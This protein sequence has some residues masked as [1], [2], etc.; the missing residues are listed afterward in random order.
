[1]PN[2]IIT[3][4]SAGAS[5]ACINLIKSSLKID[6]FSDGSQDIDLVS[7]EILVTDSRFANNPSSAAPTNYFSNIL[8]PINFKPG[9]DSVQAE[10]HSR[11]RKDASKYTILLNNMRLMAI[12]DW[13]ESVRDFLSQAP[14]T[15]KD[16][17]PQRRGMDVSV[18][19]PTATEEEPMELVLN[20]TD[21]ELVF[22]ER[23]DQWDTNAVILKST[24]IV[25]Y[26]PAEITKV[27]SINL[28][29]LE[30]FSCVLGNEE[31]TALSIIDPVTVN[32][33]LR[34]NTL[35]IQLQK[36]L[37]IRLS[38]HDLKMFIQMLESLPKQTR[39]AKTKNEIGTILAEVVA[40]DSNADKGKHFFL[41]RIFYLYFPLKQQLITKKTDS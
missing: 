29:H 8:Q 14:D 37:C 22:V 24:T 1:M 31:D 40:V 9:T 23:P 18:T 12:L 16:P 28:N 15:P 13:L 38:Y 27:M 34:K 11:R 33:D 30:V 4:S 41:N 2:E 6:S 17:M 21:S 32:L 39:N 35:D 7:Q 10:I 36:R 5:L 20:I 26:R 19:S 3:E 25:S